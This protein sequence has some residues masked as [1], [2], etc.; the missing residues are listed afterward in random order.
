MSAAKTVYSN[1]AY[2]S[3]YMDAELNHSSGYFDADDVSLDSAQQAKVK[4][5]LDRCQLQP[6]MK[7]LDVGCGWGA[8]ARVAASEHGAK[9]TGITLDGGQL[10]YA[11]NR[12]RSKPTASRIDF[13]LQR[14]EEFDEP[15]DRIICINAFENFTDRR[16]FLPHFRSLLPPD[17]VV[18][19]LTVTADRPMFR[20]VSKQE[21]IE[22]A[23]RAGFDVRVS[24]SLA[25][26]YVRTLEC[27][28]ERL[29]ERREEAI[30][31]VGADRVDRDIAFYSECAGF[32]R[33][34]L[35]DMFEFT[36]T[37]R[38]PGGQG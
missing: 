19:V 21:I 20:V 3:C 10:D 24:E 37:V 34:G 2:A 27:F 6:G 35:N 38:S 26:H 5:I 31:L 29:S 30:S 33:R 7:L 32:L 12:E 14:W 4:A 25:H 22:S 1:T 17:G 23:E 15:A 28:V 9:V 8:A 13:R 16:S 11:L 36:F 18:V